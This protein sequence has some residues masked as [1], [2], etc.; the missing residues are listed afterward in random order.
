MRKANSFRIAAIAFAAV[1]LGFFQASCGGS[2]GTVSPPP[3]P[4]PNSRVFTST[5]VG[6]HTHTITIQKSEIETPPTG[7]ISRQ[8]S[9]TGHTHTF[10][11]SE[12][13]LTTVKGGTPVVVTT[14]DTNAHT[15]DFTIQKW[16]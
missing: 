8:T 5:L 12:V 2:S 11:M 10:T 9:S 15:H 6:G 13:N 14:G 7:G 1:A 4:N 3:T 16:Y